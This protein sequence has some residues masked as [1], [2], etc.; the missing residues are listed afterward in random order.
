M[1]IIDKDHIIFNDT[2]RNT[3]D[4]EETYDKTKNVYSPKYQIKNNKTILTKNNRNDLVT[5]I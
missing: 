2:N 3:I 1:K 5:S 4:K